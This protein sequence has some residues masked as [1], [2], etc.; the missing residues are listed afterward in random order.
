MILAAFRPDT[1]ARL[2][3]ENLIV[4]TVQMVFRRSLQNVLSR[5]DYFSAAAHP[6]AFER[7]QPQPR[8][9]GQPRQLDRARR[10]PAAGA[11]SAWSRRISATEGVDY[12]GAGLSEQLF[13]TPAAIARIWRSRACTR[14]MTVSAEETADP[15]GRPLSFEWRLL[16]GDPDAGAHHPRRGRPQPRASRSTG[17]SPSRS[18]KDNP[19]RSARVDIGVFANN[20]VHDSAPA[21]LSMAFPTHETRVY[22]P[23][24]DGAPRIASI[25]HAD[26]AKARAYAD[27][28]LMAWADWRDDYAYAAD[29]TPL[30][31]T[32]S[33]GTLTEDFT[34][35]GE[36]IVTRAPDGSAAAARARRLS[37]PPRRRRAGSPSRRSPPP[38]PEDVPRAEHLRLSAPACA[39]ARPARRRGTPPPGWSAAAARWRPTS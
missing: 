34:P 9:H 16:Q 27:P 6:A 32:R 30:G 3:Q 1:K 35:D 5:D 31:W 28:M 15:N 37:P 38:G 18:P 17:T 8:P 33:R 26:P 14:A 13:D 11:G 29:G 7:Y 20:G 19:I 12:F 4:P 23:G 10:H 21:I 22:A 2:T 36:R 25:D 39:L 24:P